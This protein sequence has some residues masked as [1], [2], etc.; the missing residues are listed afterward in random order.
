MS[1][2]SRRPRVTHFNDC[3][4]VAQA[5]VTEAARQ[6]LQWG[7]MPPAEVRPPE[8]F[9][10]SFAANFR[11]A[12][13][14][15]R[16]LNMLLRSDV[17]HVHYATSVALLNH[18][19]MPKRPYFLHLHGT[20]IRVQWL[21]PAFRNQIQKAIDGAEA[22][23]YTNLDTA[24]NAQS[25]RADATYMP[26]LLSTDTLPA[27]TPSDGDS[28]VR[29][30]VFAS[31]WDESKGIEDQLA[32]AG[33][34]HRAFGERVELI[35]LD[36]G[37]GAARA[38]SLGVRL[39]S[40]LPHD[41]YVG[42]LAGADMVIGQATGLLGISELEAMAIGPVV[43]C[44][45]TQLEGPAG[46]PPVLQ[47]SIEEIIDQSAEVLLDPRGGSQRINAGSWVS[48]NHTAARWIPVLQDLY[49]SAV[50]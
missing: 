2:V 18:S 21:D 34:L 40:R 23:F 30:V 24:E 5:L 26:A 19:F 47:G 35:G 16:H 42:L 14:I 4:N 8:G 10:G 29:R 25:A 33:A 1:D 43:A 41:Q 27:W 12:P 48:E 9:S 32:M 3:A 6:G 20:D 31:R 38:A 28:P 15:A 37:E 49:R 17:I 44:P 45:G 11:K 46:R 36:W 39:R 13:F 7:Y 22:V 50:A